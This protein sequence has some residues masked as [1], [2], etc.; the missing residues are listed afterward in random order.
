MS[1]SDFSSGGGMTGQHAPLGPRR[2]A[3]A[4]TVANGFNTIRIPLVAVACW[5]L[6]DPAFDFDSSF[7]LPSF[8]DE[9]AKLA[10]LV[11]ANPGCPAAIFGHADPVGSDDV[12]KTISDRRAVAIYALLIRQPPKWEEL[13]SKA[14]DGDAWGTRSIQ[15]MLNTIPDG[16]GAPY[17]PGPIDGDYG[18]NTTSAVRTFQTDAGLAVDGDAGPNTRKVLFGAYM[19]LLCTPSDFGTDAPA[20]FHMAAADFVGQGADPN[21]KMALQGCSR[22]NPVVLLPKSEMGGDDKTTRNADDAPNRRV[23]MFLFRKGTKVEPGDWPCPRIGEPVDACKGQFWPDG[24]QRRQNGDALRRYRETPDTMACRFYDRIARRS[25]C[26]GPPSA[27]TGRAIFVRFEPPQALSYELTLGDDTESGKLDAGE[28]LD[29][30][31]PRD[32]HSGTLSVWP[33]R[34]ETL[35]AAGG[36]GCVWDLDITNLRSVDETEGVQARLN[37][38]GY[39]AG[40]VDGELAYLTKSAIRSFREEFGM[41]PTDED[42]DDET[43]TRIKKEYGA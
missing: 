2:F 16:S 35:E 29:R 39:I 18:P 40:A 42:L 36:E 4:P 17:Y 28:V 12:N 26:E 1:D 3:V 11:S 27:G 31:V 6:N 33:T 41:S 13:Y 19:D 30:A 34:F 15:T 23:L 10:R 7:V 8:R 9:L 20:P 14:V 24:E 38:L 21:G 32:V 37:N 5:R 25:P 22:F 43:R